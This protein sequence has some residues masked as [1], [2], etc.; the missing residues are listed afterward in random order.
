MEILYKM[1]FTSERLPQKEMF[2]NTDKGLAY[3]KKRN[4]YF[5]IKG[6]IIHIKYW[7]ECIEVD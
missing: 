7:F 4:N 5:T 3:F 1:V 2:V 6:S